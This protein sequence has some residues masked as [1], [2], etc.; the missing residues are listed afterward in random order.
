MSKHVKFVAKFIKIPPISIIIW[1]VTI[2]LTNLLVSSVAKY[3]Q[4]SLPSQNTESKTILVSF[5]TSFFLQDS[6]S[7]DTVVS[8]LWWNVSPFTKCRGAFGTCTWSRKEIRL[9][10]LSATFYTGKGLT[11]FCLLRADWSFF[12]WKSCIMLK[13]KIVSLNIRTIVPKFLPMY[14]F[15]HGL[16]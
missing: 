14:Q 3:S 6:P 8:D 13:V 5:L 9:S 2:S 7:K 4:R 15:I 12:F 1:R 11:R 10:T 16:K